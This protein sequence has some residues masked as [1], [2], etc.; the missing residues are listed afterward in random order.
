MC[1]IAF[2]SSCALEAMNQGL[3][4]ELGERDAPMD[5]MSLGSRMQGIV[6]SDLDRLHDDLKQ[7]QMDS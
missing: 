2:R 7:T 5:R 1:F 6:E 4:H 3:S